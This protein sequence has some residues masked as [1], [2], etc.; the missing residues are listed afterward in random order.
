M[1]HCSELQLEESPPGLPHGPVSATT[2]CVTLPAIPGDA[3]GPQDRLLQACT[4]R[5]EKKTPESSSEHLWLC[6]HWGIS[7]FLGLIDWEN[8]GPGMIPHQAGLTHGLFT[9]GLR[10]SSPV[11]APQPWGGGTPGS[12]GTVRKDI[13]GLLV[14]NAQKIR[15]NFPP[16]DGKHL[17]GKTQVSPPLLLGLWSP[18][19]CHPRVQPT[20][21][22]GLH[23]SCGV[24]GQPSGLCPGP[25]G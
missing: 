17:E 21:V 25:G 8:L 19:L 4:F 20:R 1:G 16:A 18:W 5:G 9:Q 22:G 11:A 15:L 7:L 24:G 23:S 13:S 10:P 14:T 6:S 3:G 12:S 2:T